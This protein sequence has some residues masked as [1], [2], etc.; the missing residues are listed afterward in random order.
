MFFPVKHPLP[1]VTARVD[2]K[3]NKFPSPPP[4]TLRQNHEKSLHAIRRRRTPYMRTHH[5]LRRQTT[6]LDSA[7]EEDSTEGTNLSDSR[8]SD[9]ETLLVVAKIPKPPGEAGRKNSGG[10]NLQEVLG[11]ND[12]KYKKFMVSSYVRRSI[13][14]THGKISNGSQMKRLQNLTSTNHSASRSQRQ[15]KI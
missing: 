2:F 1:V 7:D 9:D 13:I 5:S 11:W 4:I 3:F 10:F 12:E 8:E 14:L 15:S 6:P